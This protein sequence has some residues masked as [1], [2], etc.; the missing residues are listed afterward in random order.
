MPK[1]SNKAMGL[2]IPTFPTGIYRYVSADSRAF[3]KNLLASPEREDWEFDVIE[4]S[5][6]E[7][8]DQ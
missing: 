3:I 1:L 6:L 7:N 4:Y 8:P 5:I 2:L